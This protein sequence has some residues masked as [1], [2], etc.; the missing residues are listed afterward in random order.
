MKKLFSGLV[1]ALLLSIVIL[2][3]LAS[4]NNDSKLYTYALKDDG[5]AIITG[6]NWELN[7]NNNISVPETI[8]GHRITGID[9]WAFSERVDM[10]R[11]YPMGFYSAEHQLIG[12]SVAVNLPNGI[13]TIGEKSFFLTAITSVS[14]PASVKEI[15]SGAFAGCFN[16]TQFHVDQQNEVYATIEG[17]LYNKQKKELVAYPFAKSGERTYVPEGIIALGD[18]ALMGYCSDAHVHFRKN[19]SYI[20][21]PDS[22]TSIGKYSCAFGDFSSFYNFELIGDYA[23]YKSEVPYEFSD[24]KFVT[25]GA[26]A[27]EHADTGGYGP[28]EFILP[29][30]VTSLGEYAFNDFSRGYFANEQYNGLDISATRVTEIPD[31]CFGEF[32]FTD[33]VKS[34]IKLPESV[35]RIGNSAFG[36]S[37]FS[38]RSGGYTE[39]I[40]PATVKEI[41]DRAFC[42]DYK[43]KG[44]I[45]FPFSSLTMLETIGDYAFRNVDF[46]GTTDIVI[47]DSVRVLGQSIFNGKVYSLTIPASVSEIGETVAD[48]GQTKLIVSPDSFAEQ[49]AKENN[50]MYQAGVEDDTSWL[51]N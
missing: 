42:G 43:N 19:L 48:P 45:A 30:S 10:E 24:T 8:D 21:L 50:F 6:F 26:H 4:S 25:I 9:D 51:N 33:N 13:E 40:L 37:R 7:R 49:Y 29:S 39:I 31:Y 32:R 12:K 36:S 34:F 11:F 35:T 5:T 23:F 14:I 20:S 2:P 47:P 15:G 17:V 38:N 28:R 3:G 16:M 18:Y 22:I 46:Y 1:A 41:G 44:I 27:F